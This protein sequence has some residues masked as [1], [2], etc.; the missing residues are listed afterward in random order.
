MNATPP[1]GGGTGPGSGTFS[2]I[3][4]GR[5]KE[6]IDALGRG[7]HV[8][9]SADG[10]SR[11]FSGFGADTTG[12]SRLV[13][14]GNWADQ[15]L[16]SLKRRFDLAVAIEQNHPDA[17]RTLVRVPDDFLSL[18][19]AQRK[20]KELADRMNRV[21]RVDGSGAEEIHRIAGE[22][23]RFQDDPE[24]LAAFYAQ[25]GPNR[26]STLPMFLYQSGSGTGKEDLRT[27]SRGLGTASSATFLAV[28]GFDKVTQ[29]MLRPSENP[30]DAWGRLA[31]MQHGHFPTEYI[32]KAAKNLALDGFVKDPDGTDWR[33]TSLPQAAAL[34]L[35]EDNLALALNLLGK[36]GAAARDVLRGM[37]QGDL[38]KTYD[39]LLGYARSRGSGDAVAA[40]LGRAMEAGSGV[41]TE[42]P[43]RH[44][45]AAS[46]FAFHAM[47]YMA[48][49][50]EDGTPWSMKVSMANLGASY[51]HELTTGARDDDAPYRQSGMARPANW[52]DLPGLNPAFY[53]SPQD[54]YKFL[55]TFAESR[56]ATDAFDRAAGEFS[57]QAL[58][59]AA[60]TDAAAVRDGQEDPQQMSRMAGALG[61]LA[62]AEYRAQVA[63]GKDMDKQAAAVR[64]VLKDVATV[65]LGEVP[66]A[67]KAGEYLWKGAQF[68]IGKL[69]LDPWA[70]GDNPN[71]K[72]VTQE[73]QNFDRM[74]RFRMT[75]YLYES[76]YPVQPPPPEEV[77]NSDGSLKSFDQ[78]RQEA[79]R[80][81]GKDPGAA[82]QR[83]LRTLTDWT[84]STA[85]QDGDRFDHKVDD[86]A[87]AAGGT[88]GGAT[89]PV[90]PN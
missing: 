31:L 17:G 56:P 74:Q 59:G 45:L 26:L 58:R 87:E 88:I 53:L 8:L 61:K 43:G 14:I 41:G 85:G 34:G 32:R 38:K 25:L 44:S 30:S 78:L 60:K 6:M 40:G 75:K 12:L 13:A 28:P 70:Q 81:G 67:S 19:A 52:T 33:G 20:G 63:A 16:P 71:E 4:P 62:R 10:W 79:Q 36:D 37:H 77:V 49:R 57:E 18:E 23:A 80:E 51:I 69:G 9:K 64:G 46:Q 3:D 11:Q 2:G 90:A 29:M 73:Y 82:F 24:V 83:K 66:F 72:R 84:D 50:G 1:P 27:F 35:S 89:P 21:N 76:G 15:Q 39:L 86:A 42:E 68:A 5:L 47:T 55:T 65:G 54:T 22:L 7:A 48:G